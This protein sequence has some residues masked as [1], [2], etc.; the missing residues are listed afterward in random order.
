MAQVTKTTKA[1]KKTIDTIK[2]LLEQ[3]L[4]LNNKIKQDE[5]KRKELEALIADKLPKNVQEL[6]FDELGT[7]QW[8]DSGGNVT[9]DQQTLADHFTALK[10]SGAEVV[11]ICAVT[12]RVSDWKERNIQVVGQKVAPITKT[13]KI[14]GM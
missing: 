3:Y 7:I 1:T 6:T 14:K 5:A 11:E 13:I 4:S 2:P 12:P 8:A 10:L 9:W